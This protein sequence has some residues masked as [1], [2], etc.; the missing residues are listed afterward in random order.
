MMTHTP[1]QFQKKKIIFFFD[2]FFSKYKWVLVSARVTQ[3]LER[4]SYEPSVTGSNHASS[5]ESH[6]FLYFDDKISTFDFYLLIHRDFILMK[7]KNNHQ[8]S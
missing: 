8:I 7:V 3:W 4:W 2:T 1:F 6:F 5:N